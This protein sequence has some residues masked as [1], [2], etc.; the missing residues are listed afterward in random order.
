MIRDQYS[1]WLTASPSKDPTLQ[2]SLDVLLNDLNHSDL[3]I[4]NGPLVFDTDG[5]TIKGEVNPDYGTVQEDSDLKDIVK[6]F[7][8]AYP[9]YEFTFEEIDE[10][11]HSEGCITKF[12]AGNKTYEGY[13]RTLEP[14]EYDKATINAITDYLNAHG[15]P[16]AAAAVHAKFK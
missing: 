7:S 14:D 9:D 6:A 3:A 10:D 15:W 11:D 13:K 16:D 5:Q 12:V 1:Y 4:P 8:R 2:I